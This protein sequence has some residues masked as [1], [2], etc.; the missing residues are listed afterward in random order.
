MTKLLVS[1]RDVSEARDALDGGADLIDIKEPTRGSLGAADPATWRTIAKEIC[2]RRPLS[3]ALGEFNAL[4]SQQLPVI[5]AEIDFAKMGLAGCGIVENWHESWVKRL[6]ELARTVERVAV[7]YA[8][9]RLA[10]APDPLEIVENSAKAD[11]RVLL[12]DTFLKS[13]GNIASVLGE[14]RLDEI[15][16]AARR[17]GLMIVLGGSITLDILPFVVAA[18]PDYIAVRGAVCDGSRTGRLDRA[19]VQRFADELSRVS[20]QS[21]VQSAAQN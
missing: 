20:D 13:N 11:C 18:R 3:V 19:L 9:W 17:R 1:V 14:S 5:P 15:V 10:E 16:T 8:D 4:G 2:G 21:P 12:I 7:A 6:S